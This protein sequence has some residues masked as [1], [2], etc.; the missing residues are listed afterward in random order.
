ME[1]KAFEG[2][3]Y[4]AFTFLLIDAV[5]GVFLGD[6]CGSYGVDPLELPI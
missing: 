2:L 6:L 1:E 4:L 3:P 5:I